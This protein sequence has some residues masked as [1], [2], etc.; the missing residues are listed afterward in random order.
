MNA[1]KVVNQKFDVIKGKIDAQ[2]TRLESVMREIDYS[3]YV[4]PIKTSIL[5]YNSYLEGWNTMVKL[6]MVEI[7]QAIWQRR[8]LVSLA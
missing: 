5:Y 6:D 8:K 4:A 2:T 7:W 1:F 3:R